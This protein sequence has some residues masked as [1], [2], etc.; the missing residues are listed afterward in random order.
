M[1]YRIVKHPLIDRDIYDIADLVA[2]YAG[3]A[4]GVAKANDIV[5][6]IDNL[7]DFPHIGSTRDDLRTGLRAIPAGEKGV[8][9]FTVNERDQSV[10][11]I[12]VTYAGADWMARVKDREE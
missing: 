11:I 9:C 2:N 12:C 4:I 7:A 3:P 5:R 10:F 8:V 1:V 6:V